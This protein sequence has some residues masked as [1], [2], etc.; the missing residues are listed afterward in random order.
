MVAWP[1][2]PA[3]SDGRSSGRPPPIDGCSRA[4]QEPAPTDPLGAPSPSSREFAQR[5]GRAP[6]SRLRPPLMG[7][8]VLQHHWLLC[9]RPLSEIDSFAGSLPIELLIRITHDA[10]ETI[11]AFV[12]SAPEARVCSAPSF[13]F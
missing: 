9:A 1:A 6:T 11:F 10:V 2:A 13:A 3:R 8:D 5:H 7:H 4:T 12:P